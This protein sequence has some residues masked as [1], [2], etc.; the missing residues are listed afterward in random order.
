MD[1]IL[2]LLDQHKDLQIAL[3]WCLGHFDIERNALWKRITWENPVRDRIAVKIMLEDKIIVD[4]IFKDFQKT[5]SFS[6]SVAKLNH[7]ALWNR[8]LSCWMFGQNLIV[9][10][11]TVQGADHGMHQECV[12]REAECNPL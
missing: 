10:V 12:V 4:R 6:R 8:I 7:K 1:L 9:G 5:L 2:N 11:T 3:T